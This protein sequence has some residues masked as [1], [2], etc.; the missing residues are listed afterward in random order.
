MWVAVGRRAA[1][2]AAGR[3]RPTPPAAVR[4]S[5]AAAAAAAPFLRAPR[6]AGVH[7]AAHTGGAALAA[8]KHVEW[9][10]RSRAPAPPLAPAAT[11]LLRLARWPD[12]CVL[13]AGSHE[14][15]PLTGA[16]AEPWGPLLGAGDIAA[17]AEEDLGILERAEIAL[18][19]A[20][21]GG[22]GASAE[23][24]DSAAPS[25]GDAGGRS[26]SP[27]GAAGSVVSSM[28]A[29][30]SSCLSR[31]GL[32]RPNPRSG[33]WPALLPLAA[34]RLHRV[35]R[36]READQLPGRRGVPRAPAAGRRT[37]AEPPRQRAHPFVVA[38]PG[39]VEWGGPRRVARPM[40]AP[41][42]SPSSGAPATR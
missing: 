41:L 23:W 19:D 38:P 35:S 24:G 40:D 22:G 7:T 2:R 17:G 32:V 29:A 25:C 9:E 27:A 6:K 42:R 26:A 37:T 20:A 33:S 18:A 16:T 21:T 8:R 39:G 36:G 5:G 1:Q 14:P 10:P 11:A 28:K 31:R 13:R 34:P 30:V 3:V 15:A 12:A 4:L